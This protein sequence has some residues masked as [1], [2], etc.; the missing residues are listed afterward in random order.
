MIMCR[1]QKWSWN[2]ST[3]MPSS[4][5]E[6]FHG[7]SGQLSVK[8][9]N[10]SVFMLYVWAAG[11]LL[12]H[13]TLAN[14]CH[15]MA[16][17]NMICSC[18]CGC[19]RRCCCLLHQLPSLVPIL[20]VMSQVASWMR[21]RCWVTQYWQIS[22]GIHLSTDHNFL[23]IA[24]INLNTDIFIILSWD[25]TTQFLNP[26]TNQLKFLQTMILCTIVMLC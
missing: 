4:S 5:L 26:E 7:W 13:C 17:K 3:L 22:T 11:I 24:A 12:L 10:R 6:W 20:K 19:C 9:Q 23:F 15:T 25:L 21:T 14:S 2:K 1:L 8:L 16:K 18:C